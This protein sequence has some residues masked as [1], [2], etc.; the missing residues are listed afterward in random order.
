M[1]TYLLHNK[2]YVLSYKLQSENRRSYISKL[3][4]GFWCQT[5][6]PHEPNNIKY[7]SN[8]LHE[9]FGENC[10]PVHIGDSHVNSISWA[11]DLL[12]HSTSK[13]GLQQCLENTK[14]YCY[15]WGLVVNTEKTKTMVLSKH[16]YIPDC[17]IYG[18]VPLQATECFNDLGF[19]L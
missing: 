13:E 19:V 4:C 17:F 14:T 8:D 7:L 12:L 3:S 6:L 9:M 18:G 15:K 5:R 2:K 16:K 1:R 10:D 11:D